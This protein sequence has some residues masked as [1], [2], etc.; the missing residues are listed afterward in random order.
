L[1]SDVDYVAYLDADLATPIS[2]MIRLIGVIDER[3]R[4]GVQ[5]DAVIAARVAMLG[6][7]IERSPVR[8]YLGRV[9]ATAAAVA[10]GVPVYDTQCGAKVFRATDVLRVALEA[11]F[12]SKWAF[13]VELLSRLGAGHC[14]LPG[15]ESA[16]IEEPLYTWVDQPGSS[17]S[18]RA[19]LRAGLDVAVMALSRVRESR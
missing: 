18:Q 4:A 8:H 1:A 9:F 19:M 7:R 15:I 5:T 12:V 6:R 13:D 3:H 17:L 2:E 16:I 14:A 10:L 11:P